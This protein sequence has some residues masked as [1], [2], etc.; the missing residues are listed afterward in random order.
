MGHDLMGRSV[1]MA[2]DR[3]AAL[4]AEVQ[5]GLPLVRSPYAELGRRVG[6]S[7]KEVIEL[8]SAWLREGVIKRMGVIVRHRSLGYDANAMVVWDV[9]DDRVS[10]A[11]RRMSAFEFVTLCYRRPRRQHWPYNLFCMIHGKERETV[12]AQTELLAQGCGLSDVRREVLFSR[13]CFKQ[14]GA[15]Y[16]P[17][18]D[19]MMP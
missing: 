18:L 13:R 16:T 9:P 2:D 4:L 10:D 7:E 6:L 11:G 5:G 15:C 3:H 14:R 8:L 17:A 12:M 1:M 19:K